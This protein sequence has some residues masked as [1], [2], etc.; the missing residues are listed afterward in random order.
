MTSLLNILE[1]PYKC[2]FCAIEK[3]YTQE[4]EDESLLFDVDSVQQVK[5]L[6]R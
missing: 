4:E 3:R 1:C 2:F 5:Q 6:G